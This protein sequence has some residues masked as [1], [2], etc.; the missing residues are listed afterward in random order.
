MSQAGL[1]RA[2]AHGVAH[3]GEALSLVQETGGTW[4]TGSQSMSAGT[5]TTISVAGVTRLM[6]T[7]IDGVSVQA[8]DLEVWL[9]KSDLDA[10]SVTPIV[11]N[12]VV[13]GST[14]LVILGVH[15]QAAAGYYRCHARTAA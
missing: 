15:T 12:W 14:Q 7:G 9:A 11:G 1:R 6:R 2:V 5:V 3:L 4:T 8:G 13:T 10:S